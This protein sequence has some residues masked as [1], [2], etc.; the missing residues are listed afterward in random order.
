MSD[1]VLNVILAC[2]EISVRFPLFMSR[3]SW[4]VLF[5]KDSP[6]WHEALSHVSLSVPQGKIIGVIGRNGAGKSTLLRTLAGVYPPSSGRVIRLGPV[7]TLFELGGMGSFLI[8]GREYVLRWLRLNGVPRSK[9]QSL[10]EDVREFSELGDRLDQRIFTYSAGMAARLYFSTATSIS[11]EIYLIDEVLSVGDEHFQAKCWKRIRERLAFGASGVLVTHD[12]SAILRLCN[13]ACELDGGQIVSRGDVERVISKYLR[14]S[15]RLDPNSIAFFSKKCPTFVEGISGRCWNCDIPI[16]IK[17]E[18][19]IFFSYSIE[20]LMPGEE[21]QIIVIGPD[22]FI[23][24]SPGRYHARIKID[25]LPLPKGNYR[26]NLFLSGARSN[27]GS[28]RIS[29]DIRSWTTNNSI[30]MKVNGP[31]N[32]GLINM[33]LIV[34]CI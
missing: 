8:S 29:F 25:N 15:E 5:S 2:D 10:I 22:T 17:K 34:E 18:S 24:S 16:D 31:K 19:L 33:P 28:P 9:W 11:H 3:S 21:W 12:W 7:S 27:D 14:L 4:R 6:A 20:K 26:L 13:Q 1:D 32:N 23:S 30:M